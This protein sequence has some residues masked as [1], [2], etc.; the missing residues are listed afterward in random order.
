M[1]GISDAVVRRLLAGMGG[2]DL[3]VTEFVRVV[4]RPSSPKVL[5]RSC[6]ELGRGGRTANGVPVMVQ[7]LGGDAALVAESAQ[8][9][10][11]LGALGIDL[12][13]GCPAKKVNGHDG[14]AALLRTPERVRQVVDRVRRAVPRTVPVSAKIRLGWDDPDQVQDIAAA[15]EDG[16]ADWLTIHGRTKVQMYRGR[17]D[18]G[19][20]GEVARRR[21]V[22]VVANGDLFDPD[23]LRRC[24]EVTGCRAFMLGRGAFRRPN[25]FR[26]LRGLDRGP[27]PVASSMGLLL[28]F[29]DGVTTDPRYRD[30]PR[31]ALGRLKG[32]LRALSEAE[33]NFTTCFD[34]VKRL[35]DLDEARS[36]LSAFNAS[37]GSTTSPGPLRGPERPESA[38]AT[39][40][41]A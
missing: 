3:C 29:I 25:L 5:L 19:R 36:A 21:K 30:G 13:F 9:A 2:M 37:A 11:E 4:Q 7:L 24:A 12:N 38:F 8:V 23:A 14:G 31:V 35:H 27:W 26:W 18:W 40:P 15:A 20:I 33:P 6:P 28:R 16:G 41:P 39:A 22:P 17:A 10:V 32:W 34:R 1:E